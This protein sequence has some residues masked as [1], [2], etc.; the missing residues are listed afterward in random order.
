MGP[1]TPIMPTV[2]PILDDSLTTCYR[3]GNSHSRVRGLRAGRDEAHEFRSR[4]VTD[5]PFG[6]TDF[7]LDR[8]VEVRTPRK[9]PLDG[10]FDRTVSMAKQHRPPGH[11]I[12]DVAIPVDVPDS[13]ARAAFQ[14]LRKSTSAQSFVLVRFLAPLP[15]H[16]PSAL[17]ERLGAR[18]REAVSRTR[19][20][21]ALHTTA[22]PNL[23]GITSHRFW[24][25]GSDDRFATVSPSALQRGR[26]DQS[27]IGA[28]LVEDRCIHVR[29]TCSRTNGSF[30]PDHPCRRLFRWTLRDRC[31]RHHSG[32]QCAAVRN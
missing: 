29:D 7:L 11:Q 22:M 30:D 9:L 8:H 25:V 5:E 10:T 17:A 12:V 13:T 19:C 2:E 27:R 31:C 1:L 14:I 16:A 28:D 6:Q 20:G 18:D 15:D 23:A 26:V 4:N 24:S 32:S 3:S 21:G